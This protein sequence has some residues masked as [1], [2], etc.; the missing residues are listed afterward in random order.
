MNILVTAGGTTEDIDSVRGIANHA[1]G[2][3]GSLVA[4]EFSRRGGQVVYLCAE[5]ALRPE[6][7]PAQTVTIRSTAQLMRELERL[8]VAWPPDCVVHSMAVS[9]FTPAG[10]VSPDELAAAIE[11]A[12]FSCAARDV[13]AAV[14]A[15]LHSVKTRPRQGK[16]SSK[17]GELM[18][19]LEQTPKAI[20]RIKELQPSTLLVGF[21][22]LS[23]V[24]EQQ[25]HEAARALMAD[26]GCDF[27]LAN[28]LRDICG[29]RHEAVLLDRGGEVGRAGTKAEIARMIYGQVT[30]RLGRE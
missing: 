19:L 20:H 28:D 8:L 9:D 2:R 6:I 22:L 12:M 26:A 1:S 5:H 18:L 21:K 30:R 15:A 16:I 10:S 27:V 24:D 3:L 13:K 14:R 7:P 23:G 17:T 25:L 29:D 11:E 4:D